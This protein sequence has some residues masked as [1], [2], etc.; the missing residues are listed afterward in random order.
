MLSFS[1]QH[2]HDLD[3]DL[4][5][6]Q[7]AE[8]LAFST[9]VEARLD[10]ATTFTTWCEP[11]GFKEFKKVRLGR[12]TRNTDAALH[13]MRTANHSH[14]AHNTDAALHCMRVICTMHKI[15]MQHCIACE[16]FSQCTKYRCSIALRLICTMHTRFSDSVSVCRQGWRQSGRVCMECRGRA[17]CKGR[18]RTVCDSYVIRILHWG[19]IV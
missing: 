14:N 11:H 5:A 17:G 18:F 10:V 8:L 6:A 3:H 9:M 7:R 16:S 1:K 12:N 13:C 15:Q 2:V 19:L 4:T